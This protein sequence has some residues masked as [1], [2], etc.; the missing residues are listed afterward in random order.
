V[1]LLR[2]EARRSLTFLQNHERVYSRVFA[3]RCPAQGAKGEATLVEKQDIQIISGF[4]TTHE[5][6][7]LVGGGI[8]EVEPPA[9]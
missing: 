1:K 2:P 4:T 3:S 5:R 8:I 9:G 7:Q 6:K